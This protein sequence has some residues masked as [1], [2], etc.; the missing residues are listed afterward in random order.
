M[1]GPGYGKGCM[2]HRFSVVF[3]ARIWI[4]H[5]Q[6]AQT[7]LRVLQC[8]LGELLEAMPTGKVP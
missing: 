7:A 6:K 2:A 1:A 4:L 5:R 3:V 8:Q